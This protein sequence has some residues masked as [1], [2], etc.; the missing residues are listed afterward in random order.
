[1]VEETSTSAM[2]F[3]ARR[4]SPGPYDLA[5]GVVW[6]AAA[7]RL[8]WVDVHEGQVIEAALESSEVIVKRTHRLGATV[9]AV[10]PDSTGGLLAV[11]GNG[12]DAIAV[13]GTVR[14]GP[15]LLAPGAGSRLNDGACDPAGR[16]LV[17]SMATDGR[18]G[19]ESLFRVDD[20]GTAEVVASGLTLSNGIGWSPD[21]C[22]MFHIDSLPGV[23]RSYPY[24]PDDGTVGTCTE[25]FRIQD[26]IPDGMC[27]DVRGNLWI[28]IWGKG[29]VRCYTPKGRHLATVSVPAPRTSSAAFV[30]PDL[31]VLAI[32]TARRRPSIEELD[33]WPDAGRLFLAD[34]G[35]TGLAATPWAGH[36]RAFG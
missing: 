7:A 32:T 17:G 28:A 24:D 25:C 27:V 20:G 36:A 19:G 29:Q 8:L 30:G 21:A 31:N 34:V 35:V 26:G 4:T 16:L 9:G 2:L 22:T 11:R 10:V 1:M 5:E 12:L 15:R 6:D 3:E 18:E 13:D 23:V 14:H 33:R